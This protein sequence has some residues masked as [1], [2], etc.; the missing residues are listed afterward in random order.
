MRRPALVLG[1]HGLGKV[2]PDQDPHGLM[3]PPER[4]ESHV[5]ILRRRGYEFV[6]Q[7]EFVRRLRE[8]GAP[9]ARTAALTFDD[10]P[11]DNATVLPPRLERLGVPATLFVNSGLLGEPYRWVTREAGVRVMDGDQLRQVAA[12]PLIEI[13]CHTREH[14]SLAEVDE[15]RALAIMESSKAELEELLDL[16]VLSFAYPGCV[17]SPACPRAARRAGFTSATTCGGLGGWEP[18]EL[19]RESPAPSDGR[20]LFELKAHGLFHPLRESWPGR[21]VRRHRRRRY[22]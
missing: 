20:L 2:P 19:R 21:L 9:P 6:T 15:E 12:H 4:F 14:T 22:G 5:R 8:S 10:G 13:G 7:R 16:E 11:E 17:Y 18:F 1:Y 3:I